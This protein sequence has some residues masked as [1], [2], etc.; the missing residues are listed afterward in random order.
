ML[1][2]TLCLVAFVSLLCCL[3]TGVSKSRLNRLTVTVLFASLTGLAY[4][5]YGLAGGVAMVLGLIS[6]PVIV[7]A[8]VHFSMWLSW[9][10]IRR[11]HPNEPV[12]PPWDRMR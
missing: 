10:N 1:Q 7:F 2:L 6:L 9:Q 4:L 12:T 11:K 8:V 3:G 5:E